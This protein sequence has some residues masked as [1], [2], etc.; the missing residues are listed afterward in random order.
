MTA[1]EKWKGFNREVS[2][3]RMGAD[4]NKK[5][6]KKLSFLNVQKMSPI[7]AEKTQKFAPEKTRDFV[8]FKEYQSLTLKNVKE[9]CEKFYNEPR[10]SCDVLYSDKGPSCTEDEQIQ[11]KQFFQVRFIDPTKTKPNESSNHTTDPMPSRSIGSLSNRPSKRIR[12]SSV[13]RSVP[14][15]PTPAKGKGNFPKSISM[16]DVLKAGK[17]KKPSQETKTEMSLEFFDIKS[18][19]W[20]KE[21]KTLMIKEEKFSEGAF[22]EAFMAYSIENGTR[23]LFVVK[24]FKNE[25]WEKVSKVY[26]MNLEEHTRKQVQMHMAAKAIADRLFRKLKLSRRDDWFS[27]NDAFFSYLED[28][29][30]TVEPFVPGDF[31]K[32]IN[33]DGRIGNCKSKSMKLLYEKAEALCHFSYEDSGEQLL[34]VDLQGS[35]LILYDP[36]IATTVELEGE[37]FEEKFFCGGNLNDEA[38]D[39]FFRSHK[40]NMYCKLLSLKVVEMQDGSETSNAQQD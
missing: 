1:R 2:L 16:G 29:P 14:T 19:I 23:H 35:G 31:T 17:L 27:Y 39:T 32:Y 5:P 4:Q 38:M 20:I 22:R 36:E 6:T 34:L 28:V 24:K 13:Q 10:G 33:N 21:N 18:K 8:D 3:K 11:G 26:G 15:R 30:V 40:C 7:A 9:A 25:S 37:H 12:C